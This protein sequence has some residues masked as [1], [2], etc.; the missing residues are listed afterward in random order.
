MSRMERASHRALS[1]WAT[2]P[3]Q[4]RKYAQ[5]LELTHGVL[6]RVNDDPGVEAR[7]WRDDS[8]LADAEDVYELETVL[9]SLHIYADQE[10]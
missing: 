8:L 7:N 6:V 3:P 4:E 5:Q 10:D 2:L 1:P 9:K